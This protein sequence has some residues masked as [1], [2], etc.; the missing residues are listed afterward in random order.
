MIH[1][2]VF[3]VA[4]RRSPGFPQLLPDQIFSVSISVSAEKGPPPHTLLVQLRFSSLALDTVVRLPFGDWTSSSISGSAP[5]PTNQKHLRPSSPSVPL[6]QNHPP[7]LLQGQGHLSTVLLKALAGYFQPLV[8]WRSI[9][10]G[11]PW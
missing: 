10:C 5:A 8:R 6:G 7:T 9:S 1:V 2:E 4:S 3:P 11:V